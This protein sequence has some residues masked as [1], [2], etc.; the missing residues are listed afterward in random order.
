VSLNHR[1]IDAILD[2]L[3]LEDSHI[4][5]VRQPDF[6]SL[7]FDLYRPKYRFSLLISLNPGKTRLHRLSEKV[8][9]KTRLQ[10][11]A[12]FLRSR[13]QGGR[14]TEVYQVDADRI[15]KTVVRKGDQETVLWIRLWGGAA[16]ILATDPEGTVL[17]AFY[18]RP[19][20]NEVSGAF[21]NPELNPPPGGSKK[22]FEKRSFGETGSFNEQVERYYSRIES[23]EELETL[24]TRALKAADG[25]LRSAESLRQNIENRIAS[26]SSFDEFRE[27]GDLLKSNLHRISRGDRWFETENFFRG[28][29]AVRI[30]LDPRLSPEEN[31]E[32]YYK[33][34]KKARRGM[35]A[36]REE[37][38]NAQMNL[39]RTRKEGKNIAA[40]TDPEFL[41]S[42][43]DE[44]K[45]EKPSGRDK[46]VPG[47]V[48]SSGG[49]I[50]RVGRSSRENDALLRTWARGNDFWIHAR[51]WPGAYVFIRAKKGKSVP[52][53]V[54]LDA[55]NLA[56]HY[57]RG[58][59]AGRGDL[60]YTRVKYLRRVKDGKTGLVIP[61]MEKNL[62]IVLD[63]KRLTALFEG[64]NIENNASM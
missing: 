19:N 34:Y 60:Y 44:Y 15:I 17:D 25:K 7:I 53:D 62:D 36:L 63:E 31:A 54:L 42:Y 10:R 59:S 50:I 26:Y 49:F 52:L 37:L 12:Q 48:Y 41:R 22:H 35:D 30:E 38:K 23:E 29:A 18:R 64:R 20:R 33:K 1:E 39:E 51:D 45:K 16:N 9:V 40:S 27:Y 61:T 3:P 56:L 11:F 4:Q 24:K 47:L 58:K 28:G 2:E 6:S 14:I 13:I 57:S 55:G 5:K 46:D 32:E 8:P 43:L 21:Y